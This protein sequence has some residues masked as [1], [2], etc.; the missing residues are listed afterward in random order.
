MVL[1]LRSCARTP[2]LRHFFSCDIPV[3][4]SGRAIYGDQLGQGFPV[5]QSG[6][7]EALFLGLQTGRLLRVRH[8]PP[9]MAFLYISPDDFTRELSK[10]YEGNVSPSTFRDP[11]TFVRTAEGRAFHEWMIESGES[12]ELKTI[13]RWIGGLD[14]IAIIGF[15]HDYNLV[16]EALSADQQQLLDSFYGPIRTSKFRPK[17][18]ASD[19]FDCDLLKALGVDFAFSPAQ[20]REFFEIGDNNPF[21]ALFAQSYRLS[22]P[23]SGQRIEE[24]VSYPDFR[25]LLG[26]YD[27]TTHI[28]R[29][30][31]RLACTHGATKHLLTTY[32]W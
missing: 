19:H 9:N 23:N 6:K 12:E 5:C 3:C 20:C 24:L 14:E 2:L 26:R 22:S 32:H 8:S 16:R 4:S 30:A 29:A 1:G 15:G 18:V 10:R 11:T 28:L 27:A 31:Y 21:V 13:E 25:N 17:K 7:T